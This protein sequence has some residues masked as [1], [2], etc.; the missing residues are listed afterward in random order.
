MRGLRGKIRGGRSHWLRDARIARFYG[1]WPGQLDERSR[2]ILDK[3]IDPLWAEETLRDRYQEFTA[4]GLQQ[5]AMLAT[6]DNDFAEKI[7]SA[8]KRQEMRDSTV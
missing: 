6:S 7:W 8:K 2:Y 5:L 4:E 1:F 3:C